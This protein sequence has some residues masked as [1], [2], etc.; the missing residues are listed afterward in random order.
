MQ[1]SI[2]LLQNLLDP[3]FIAAEINE[4][5]L[6]QFFWRPKINLQISMLQSSHITET[7]WTAAKNHEEASACQG[8][9]YER[10]TGYMR[11]EFLECRKLHAWLLLGRVTKDTAPHVPRKASIGR[12][13]CTMPT[14]W[15]VSLSQ[16]IC[17]FTI[18]PE[19][20]KRRYGQSC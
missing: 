17:Q 3:V 1:S 15:E 13:N 12:G 2:M 19:H 14:S 9:E 6:G 4:T 20:C 11:L 7:S 8:S 16:D 18:H 5:S 10:K